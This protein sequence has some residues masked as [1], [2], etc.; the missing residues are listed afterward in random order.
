MEYTPYTLPLI[1]AAAIALGLAIFMLRRRPV[2]G[3]VPF[4][5]LT[6][7]V[8]IWSAGYALEISAIE[9]ADKIFWA[10]FQYLGIAAI[11]LLWLCFVF[12]FVGESEWMTTR[13][14]G[15]LVIVPAFTMLMAW[16]NEPL[17]LIWADIAVDR[18]LGFSMLVFQYGP[19]FWLH[20]AYSYV[21]LLAGTLVLFRAI[22]RLPRLGVR[23]AAVVLFAALAPWLGNAL[24]LS[25]ANP[26]PLLDLTPFSFVLTGLA[27]AWGMGRFQFMST[28]PIAHR[29]IIEGMRAGVVALDKDD[30]VVELNPAAERMFDL[31]A[32]DI[33]GRPVASVFAGSPEILEWFTSKR[34]E[35]I[36]GMLF[37]RGEWHDFDVS[38]MLLRDRQ[39]HV[40]RLITFHDISDLARAEREAEQARDIAE[41]ASQAKSEFLANVSHEIRTPLNAILGMTGLVLEDDISARNREHLQIARSSAD[42]LLSIIN[43]I[44][45]VSKI[46]ERRLE[47]DHVDF[48]LP[49]LVEET[50]QMLAVTVAG[51]SLALRSSI[52][53]DVPRVVSGDPLRLRQVLFNLLSNAIK[54][55]ESGTVTL[56]L[57]VDEQAAPDDRVRLRFAVSDTGIGINAEDKERIFESFAQ[58]DASMTRVYG[59]TGLGLSIAAHLVSLMNGDIEVESELG[60]GST[61]T[62]RVELSKSDADPDTLDA[63][64]ILT[65]QLPAELVAGADLAAA[66][67][68]VDAPPPMATAA[69]LHVLVAD[70]NVINQRLTRALLESRGHR[71]SIVNDGKEAVEALAQHDFD[72]VLMDVQMPN[73]DGVEATRAVRAAEAWTGRHVPIIAITAHAMAGDRERFLDAGMDAYVPKP[74]D[75]KVLFGT[76]ERL[77]S[78]PPRAAVGEA[79]AAQ[80]DAPGTEAEPSRP[81]PVAAPETAEP[82]LATTDAPLDTTAASLATTES[83]LE[84]TGASLA[85]T[86]SPPDTRRAPLE[87]TEPHPGPPGP[88]VRAEAT[89]GAAAAPVDPSVI[90]R[91]AALQKLA[92]DEELL[93]EIIDLYLEDAPAVF[94]RLQAAVQAGDAEGVW[95]AAHRIKGSVG[96]LSATR[97]FEAARELES[98]GRQSDLAAVPVA[99]ATLEAEMN[100]LAGA[101]AE[102]RSEYGG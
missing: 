26:F 84:T 35:T 68:A 94:A 31:R 77:L 19:G 76:I 46:E 60:R 48:D 10:K 27:V 37:I 22:V 21:L 7:A 58:A 40:G 13:R 14:F 69:G 90:D 73:L 43:D 83:P 78:A 63:A 62:F 88:T 30:N 3:R 71:I 49:R 54:F 57:R 47:L 66:A 96:S 25:G 6:L 33:V 81:Q 75:A 53:S 29:A 36:R 59:G 28:V 98:L 52:A 4:G 82:A 5:L 95:K 64:N 61:F 24:Y 9:V 15:L 1:V 2:P 74:L 11:P 45:D 79:L 51:K 99:F 67:D 8:A 23:Q 101:L 12:F 85:T 55:T 89:E 56:T 70:D 44:L 93:V 18:S 16:F 32:Q 72:V 97:A 38:T 50:M 42:S 17:E 20:T 65:P 80:P 39:H 34:D 102:L 87:S 86:E 92:G 41:A 91:N 100:R